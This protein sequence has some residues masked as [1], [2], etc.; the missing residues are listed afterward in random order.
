[1]KV[2]VTLSSYVHFVTLCLFKILDITTTSD[3]LMLI[4]SDALL[5]I[6]I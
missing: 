4:Y 1:M 6:K 5:V 2:T 3:A